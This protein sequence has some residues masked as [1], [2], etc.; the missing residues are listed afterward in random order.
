MGYEN[1]SDIQAEAVGFFNR[2]RKAVVA[3]VAAGVGSF[4]TALG[5]LAAASDL[6]PAKVLA[7]AGAAVVVALGG[8][9]ITYQ[10]KA[11]ADDA[12]ARAAVVR[13]RSQ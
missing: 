1:P 10:S 4:G 12:N 7:A 8:L 11:N 13:P 9:G 6:D 3:S 5:A 2:A